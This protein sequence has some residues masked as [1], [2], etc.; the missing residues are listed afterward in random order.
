M[1]K[2]F[3]IKFEFNKEKILEK[4]IS[5]SAS[6]VVGYICVVNANVVVHANRNE[7]YLKTINNSLINICD[8]SLIAFLCSK[9]KKENVESYAGPDLFMD[10][11]NAR[12]FKS[13]F[14]GSSDEI[15]KSM[16]V[17]LADIDSEIKNYGFYS[18]PFVVNVENFDY[19]SIGALINKYNPEIIWVSLG[20]PKQ[21]IF[22]SLLQ[23]YINKGVMVGVGAAFTFYSG[24]ANFRRAP[25]FMR[26]NRLEWLFR[27]YLEP[28]KT[29]RRI[30]AEIIYMPIIVYKELFKK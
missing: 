8:G 10:C 11:I 2:I 5:A 21:E 9:I 24:H 14:L 12:K 7:K 23:P 27:V 4:I 1:K 30:M 26:K 16:M 13:F 20:A 25:L 6:A 18:P 22:M 15:I 3:N 29:L 28:K 17:R 19:E